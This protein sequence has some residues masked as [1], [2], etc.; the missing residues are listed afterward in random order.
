M[1]PF[2]DLESV[3]LVVAF[4]ALSCWG[5]QQSRAVAGSRVVAASIRSRIGHRGTSL[6]GGIDGG[7]SARLPPTRANTGA[8]A[9]TVSARPHGRQRG[10]FGHLPPV[11]SLRF[12]AHGHSS[13]QRRIPRSRSA[14]GS[15]RA[16]GRRRQRELVT[17]PFDV[18]QMGRFAVSRFAETHPQV[19]SREDLD[20]QEAKRRAIVYGLVCALISAML[21][22][23]AIASLVMAL[24]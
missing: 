14:I 19:Y 8:P 20:E 15:A 1:D 5:R 2:V 6:V 22:I 13:G 24:S 11:R 16:R 18:T 23:G 3:G 21:T 4:I 9:D 7:K 17:V 12:R 10:E